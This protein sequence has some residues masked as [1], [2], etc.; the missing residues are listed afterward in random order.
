MS[1]HPRS[2]PRPAAT[3]LSPVAAMEY[4]L[5]T[6]PGVK[7]TPT[8]TAATLPLLA[9]RQ[10]QPVDTDG[11]PLIFTP[12]GTLV[13]ETNGQGGGIASLN[14]FAYATN[15]G[16]MQGLL[17][18]IFVDA[19][20]R[21]LRPSWRN[22]FG[23]ADDAD[24]AEYVLL[25]KEWTIDQAN[26]AQRVNTI[27]KAKT[28]DGN[29]VK[30]PKTAVVPCLVGHDNISNPVWIVVDSFHL[31]RVSR[32]D[33]NIV[34]ARTITLSAPFAD[35]TSWFMKVDS[36]I[37]EVREQEEFG[38]IKRA[39]LAGK[40]KFLSAITFGVAKD[41]GKV[42]SRIQQQGTAAPVGVLADE[43]VTTPTFEAPL[44]AHALFVRNANK[45]EF[46]NKVTEDVDVGFVSLQ[47]APILAVPVASEL[48]K[49][50]LEKYITAPINCFD[51]ETT[52]LY[53]V[54]MD[55]SLSDV[56]KKE[57]ERLLYRRGTFVV[58]DAFYCYRVFRKSPHVNIILKNPMNGY[59]QI[60]LESADV[61]DCPMITLESAD[62]GDCP[63]I[64]LRLVEKSRD[65]PTEQDLAAEEEKLRNSLEFAEDTEQQLA[66]RRLMTNVGK[67]SS[68][69]T[70]TEGAK[71][72]IALEEL[73]KRD[74]KQDVVLEALKRYRD[75][76]AEE[77]REMAKHFKRMYA[78]NMSENVLIF[79]LV[80]M[81]E[82]QT[83]YAGW[84]TRKMD[85]MIHTLRMNEEQF[86]AVVAGVL[87]LKA[88]FFFGEGLL[89]A[90]EE[91]LSFSSLVRGLSSSFTWTYISPEG[92][93]EFYGKSL[94]EN[95]PDILA[96][97]PLYGATRIGLS[98]L[99]HA[100]HGF[101]TIEALR[102][103][104][105]ASNTGR[106]A[107]TAEEMA[108]VFEVAMDI[109]VIPWTSAF[110]KHQSDTGGYTFETSP[111][112][113]PSPTGVNLVSGGLDLRCKPGN[114]T[115]EGVRKVVYDRGTKTLRISGRYP[116]S[117]G[118]VR[119]EYK[120]YALFVND[121]AWEMAGEMWT[122]DGCESTG[123]TKV[124]IDN[125]SLVIKNDTCEEFSEQLRLFFTID[126]LFTPEVRVKTIKSFI[127]DDCKLVSGTEA[128]SRLG[129]TLRVAL[130]V[131][132]A[133]AMDLKACSDSS[134]TQAILECL[135]QGKDH[136]PEF[137]SKVEMIG[138]E[139][140][141]SDVSREF[142]V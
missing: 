29:V 43:L 95:A 40:R 5:S 69:D 135:L 142:C 87:A 75:G 32:H 113:I 80:L 11:C 100:K 89:E 52:V 136:L 85:E 127:A 91:G 51:S 7:C 9:L 68:T 58:K 24:F 59:S 22:A 82:D 119:F 114:T 84:M 78:V 126:E 73:S 70:F 101:D 28:K 107:L 30:L 121:A 79:L 55:R 123:E 102:Q 76:I 124:S 118:I 125:G 42:D 122:P 129:V 83:P 92:N 62:V 120:Y 14:P 17:K 112:G 49:A 46:W 66:F 33:N 93:L 35:L 10:F 4:R 31:S 128:A 98:M 115:F 13:V 53:R 104:S 21:V 77:Y 39:M 61:G 12:K 116:D 36:K 50:V 18:P 140:A 97:G 26:K 137:V 117:G 63:M 111:L 132:L 6:R 20:R 15:E 81:I 108:D 41:N 131:V 8:P 74:N 64:M 44:K 141:I 23:T 105:N 16:V 37:R 27:R 57:M 1:Y 94:V 60:M 47:G 109:K 88:G 72:V 25:E 96:L 86:E 48:T 67:S 65:W 56:Q 106:S 103:A 54:Q 139:M 138:T 99:Q 19:S 3:T 2:R 134:N 130:L 110:T 34:R 71:L 90:W 133:R 45:S 38:V